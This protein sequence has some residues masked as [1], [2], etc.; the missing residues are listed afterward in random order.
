EQ[1]IKTLEGVDDEEAKLIGGWNNCEKNPKHVNF[2]PVDQFTIKMLPESHQNQDVYEYVKTVS[3]LTVLV[4]VAFTS[5]NRPTLR[6]DS[7][8]HYS[9]H[10]DRK[11]KRYRKA[12]GT[13]VAV[14]HYHEPCW[15]S[16]CQSSD[17]PSQ[18]RWELEVDTA[19]HVVFDELE[20]SHTKL[21]LFFDT[22]SSAKVTLSDV[23][24]EASVDIEKD[25]CRLC[26]VT[27]D[28]DLGEKLQGMFKSYLKL[29]DAVYS[30]YKRIRNACQL[31]IIVSHPHGCAK[32]ISLGKWVDKF[33]AEGYFKKFTYTTD[34]CPGS[35][36][37]LVNLIGFNKAWD[38]NVHT[39]K[40]GPLNFSSCGY[41][42]PI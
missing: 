37:A 11:V 20:A 6:A 13:V 5:P 19:S 16:N 40:D 24:L 38:A 27:C 36:G 22:R 35:S 28:K 30:K 7:K 14:H 18:S 10:D 42:T 1:E 29:W 23:R 3:G 39:G 2:I 26:C 41:F 4:A 15:C 8:L 9:M 33:Q 17:L 31:A 32:H 34:T 21:T 25:I 12:S